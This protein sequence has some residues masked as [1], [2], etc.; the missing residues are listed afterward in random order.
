MTKM[1]IDAKVVLHLLISSIFAHKAYPLAPEET[2]RTDEILERILAIV[3]PELGNIAETEYIARVVTDAI[4]NYA[5]T[6][7]APT[8]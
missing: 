8:I 6:P 2:E 7:K 1:W 4:N 3:E 5:V